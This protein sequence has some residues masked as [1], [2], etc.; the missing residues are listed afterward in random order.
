MI[1]AV[2]IAIFAIA[3]KPV[4][5]RQGFNGIRTDGLCVS[6]AVLYQLNYE[7]PYIGNRPV[8]S[9]HRNLGKE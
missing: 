1:K 5:N 2:V 9:V 8:C 4:K 6:A 3:N 7:D